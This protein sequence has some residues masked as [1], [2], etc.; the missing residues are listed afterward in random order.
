[1]IMKLVPVIL[2]PGLGWDCL[3]GAEEE[4]Q[5]VSAGAAGAALRP[6]VVQHAAVPVQKEATAG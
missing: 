6:S 3:C 5:Q 1:M 2:E 4:G